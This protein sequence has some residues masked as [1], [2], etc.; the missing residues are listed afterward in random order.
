MPQHEYPRPQLVRE[1]WQSL[2]GQWNFSF[3]EAASPTDVKWTHQIVV[4]YPPESKLSGIHDESFHRVVWYQRDFDAPELDNG[5]RLI[6]HFGAV[7]YKCDVWVNGHHLAQHTGGH[8]PFSMDVTDA[9]TSNPNHV[10]VRAYD[11][12]HELSKPRGK[13]DWHEQPHSIFYPRTTGIWQTVWL[14]RVP[15]QRIDRIVMKPDLP[16][17]AFTFDVRTTEAAQAAGSVVAKARIRNGQKT[18]AEAQWN[19]KQTSRQTLHLERGG[20]DDD[21]DLLW[22]PE[23]PNLLDVDL[24]L[25]VDGVTVDRVQ[26]YTALRSIEG[27]D[28]MVHLNGQPYFLRLALDQ[29]Y[30]DDTLLAA[31]DDDALRTD[32][33]LAKAMGFNGVRKHQKIEDPRYLYWADRLGLLVWEELP[34]AYN[35]TDRAIERLNQEWVEAIHR[36]INHPCIM[37]WVPFNESWGVPNLPHVPAQRSAVR[38]FYHLTKSLD[39]SRL[40]VG[41]DGWEHVSTDL[42]TIHDYHPDPDVIQARYGTPEATLAIREA[43]L[44]H[45]RRIVLH[46]ADDLPSDLPAILSEF[47]GIRFHPEAEGWGYQEVE[48]A[49]AFI[50]LYGRMIKPLYFPGV[51]GFCYTQF[52]DTFQEQNGLLFSDRTPKVALD[53]LLSATE[54]NGDS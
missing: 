30:W 11:D 48:N 7:D 45:G 19:V 9:L 15:E 4:P 31:P 25:E 38:G 52:A 32:V 40:V 24:E 21:R 41:N 22:S 29:G 47:G 53:S 3:D 51:A 35:F 33:E 26:S 37:A 43:T 16:G 39:D 49:D 44:E 46:D 12:P 8:T 36:D 14:E 18:V 27:R 50:D 20:L 10:T 13:Q 54:G 42:L 34:S 17:Y 2:N 6:L 23:R 1:H 28:G 5:E